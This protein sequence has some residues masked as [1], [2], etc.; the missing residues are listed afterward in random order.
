M[1]TRRDRPPNEYWSTYN[2]TPFGVTFAPKPRSVS[3]QRRTSAS[4]VSL[5]VV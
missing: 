1:V 3:C 4:I 5:G 2:R